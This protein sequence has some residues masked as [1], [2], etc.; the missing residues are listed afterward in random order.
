TPFQSIDRSH[1]VLP[2]F[3]TPKNARIQNR[4]QAKRHL[5][6]SQNGVRAAPSGA[7]FQCG[8]GSTSDGEAQQQ[9]SQQQESL[10][11]HAATT[12]AFDTFNTFNL[13]PPPPSTTT[14]TTTTTTTT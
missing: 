9:Q 14:A 2:E 3:N 7:W 1:A 6:A 8:R 13:P 11:F 4:S 5:P 12:T 10:S